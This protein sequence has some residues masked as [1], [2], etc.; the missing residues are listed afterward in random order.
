MENQC[1]YRGS[2]EARVVAADLDGTLLDSEGA[3]SLRTR[4]VLEKLELAGWPLVI[5]TSRP[6]REVVGIPGLPRRAV[7]ICGNG[8]VICDLWQGSVLRMHHMERDLVVR[9]VDDLRAAC[10]DARLGGEVHPELFLEPGFVLGETSLPATLTTSEFAAAVGVR[11]L[12]K[13]IVQM[14]G[15]ADDYV[16]RVR[17]AVPDEC[18]V[19]WSCPEFCEVTSKQVNK[20]E[21]LEIV[22]ERF[23][24]S[25]KEVIAFGDMPNDLSMFAWAG[26]SVAMANAHEAVLTAADH[27]TAS[28]DDHGVAL[29][30]EGRLGQDLKYDDRA[31]AKK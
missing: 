19:T 27:V 6:L 23:G 4:D 25:A 12:A 18:A 31:F 15:N 22:M 16:A 9:L 1:S 5:A 26:W 17:S 3:L 10:P 14:S 24:Y 28:N 29:Y 20:S 21:A 2:R 7:L 8:T 30:L 11:G 13:L